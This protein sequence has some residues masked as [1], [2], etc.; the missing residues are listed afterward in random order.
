MA[1]GHDEMMM[2]T[3]VGAFIP[4]CPFLK[5]NHS[6][7]HGRALSGRPYETLWAGF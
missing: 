2:A 1:K 4:Y 6:V 3:W 5:N 7:L